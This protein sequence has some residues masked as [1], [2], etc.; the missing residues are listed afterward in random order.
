MKTDTKITQRYRDD[1]AGKGFGNALWQLYGLWSFGAAAA[2]L[3]AVSLQ[4][5]DAF[6][7][8]SWLWAYAIAVDAIAAF[9]YLRLPNS[10]K[11][12]ELKAA[13]LILVLLEVLVVPS[14]IAQGL[15]GTTESVRGPLAEFARNAGQT[16]AWVSLFVAPT[17]GFVL[18]GWARIAAKRGFVQ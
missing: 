1:G 6:G 11:S 9:G 5:S 2:I 16:A 13:F 14:C 7:L 15:A 18:T 4:G 10:G 8:P 17:L 3:T 12:R